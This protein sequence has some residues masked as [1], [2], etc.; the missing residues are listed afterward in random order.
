M[1]SSQS[2]DCSLRVCPTSGS[3]DGQRPRFPRLSSEPNGGIGGSKTVIVPTLNNFEEK[4]LI[5]S[6]RINLEEFAISFAIVQYL[7]VA[8]GCHRRDIEIVFGFDV[9]VVVFGNLQEL[10]AAPSHVRDGCEKSLHENATC[11]TPDPKNSLMKRAESVRVA[12]EPLRIRRR[13]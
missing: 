1:T 4:P 10:S 8:K 13:A 5:E 3:G 2:S 7:V 6:V 12:D 9:V 11:W